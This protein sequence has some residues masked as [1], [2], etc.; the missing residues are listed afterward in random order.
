MKKAFFSCEIEMVK[1]VREYY[2]IVPNRKGKKGTSSL[3]TTKGTTYTYEFWK[4][5]AIGYVVGS[6]SITY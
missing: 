5:T 1:R 2:K 6:A 4:P 3:T